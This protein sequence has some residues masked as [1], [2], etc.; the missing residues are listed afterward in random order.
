VIQQAPDA[1]RIREIQQALRDRGYDA[2]VTG[3]WDQRS[4]QALSKF[5]ADQNINNLSGRGKLDSLTL[6]ALGLGPK[7]DQAASTPKPNPEGHQP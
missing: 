6:I 5:Q 3:S 1:E 7:Y 4:V 2:E